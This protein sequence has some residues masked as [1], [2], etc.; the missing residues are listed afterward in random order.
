MG[1]FKLAFC[2]R[3]VT[4]EDKGAEESGVSILILTLWGFLKQEGKE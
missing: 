1:K 3:P 2:S 4:L